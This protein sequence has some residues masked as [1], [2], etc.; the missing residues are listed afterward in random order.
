MKLAALETIHP[1]PGDTIVIVVPADKKGVPQFDM[2]TIGE[3]YSQVAAAFPD[4]RVIYVTGKMELEHL[5]AVHWERREDGKPESGKDVF[6][7]RKDGAVGEGQYNERWETW[8]LY[9][10]TKRIPDDDVLAW[11]ELPLP[12][13]DEDISNDRG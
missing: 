6:I 11:A 2:M 13:K 3:T 8:I 1:N 4:H 10:D 5:P 7:C 9:K 12:L